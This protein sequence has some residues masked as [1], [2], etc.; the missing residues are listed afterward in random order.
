MS[1]AS[2]VGMDIAY[3][4]GA[5]DA[6]AGASLAIWSG[7]IVALLG[8]NGSGKTTLLRI[9]MGF[10]APAGGRVLLDGAPIE[11]LGRRAI[12]R[13]IAYVAQN[14]A[15]PFPYLVRDVVALGRLP[16]S[17]WRPG[18]SAHEEP[19]VDEALRRLRISHLADRPYTEIS[20][21]ERQ[22]AMLGRALAQG[23]EILVLDEPMT[24]LDYG[25]QLRLIALLRGLAAEARGI[26]MTT[27]HPEHAHWASDRVAFLEKGRI[28]EQGPPDE[29]LTAAAIER[30]YGVKVDTLETDTGRRLFGPR[31][32]G[33]W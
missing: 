4:R 11:K 19:H 5:R 14:H 28:A 10:L 21:G 6:L 22:L 25:A 29:V 8:A 31:E 17:G 9:L 13:K 27:H 7:E 23:A 32:H 24:G 30:L 20:G 16:H 1:A 18:A 26:V 15:A 2:L 12:A 3:R 33:S